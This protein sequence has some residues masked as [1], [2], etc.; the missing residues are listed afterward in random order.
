MPKVGSTYT[1]VCRP[2]R[3]NAGAARVGHCGEVGRPHQPNLRSGRLPVQAWLWAI[4][5]GST[6]ESLAW[7]H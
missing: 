5:G 3:E 1:G 4:Y 6:W 7:S 2:A